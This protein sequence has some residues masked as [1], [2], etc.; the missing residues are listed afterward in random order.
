M[1]DKSNR[2]SSKPKKHPVKD[3]LT[4]PMA[5]TTIGDHMIIHASVIVMSIFIHMSFQGWIVFLHDRMN[6]TA[7]NENQPKGINHVESQT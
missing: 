5:E 3:F 1:K 7:Y 6:N 4:K 2:I